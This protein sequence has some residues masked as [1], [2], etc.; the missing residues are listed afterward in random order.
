MSYREL[1][2]LCEMARTLKYPR[3]LSI[4]NFRNPN[5]KLVAELLQ[6]IVKKFDPSSNLNAQNIETEQDRVM[7][8]KQAVLLLLQNS[9]LKL[10]PKK[11]YQ[12]DGYAVQELIP[13]LKILYDASKG[14]EDLESVAQ[15][16][17]IKQKISSKM[18]EVRITRQLSAQ[19]PET[20]AALNDLLTKQIYFAKQRDRAASRAIALPEAEKTVQQAISAITAE[21]DEI[22]SRLNNVASDEAELDEKIERKKREYEQ[23]QKRLAKL[24]SFRPQYMDEY[25]KYEERLKQLYTVYVTNYRNLSYL[26]KVHDDLQTADRQKQ[27]ENERAMRIAVEKMRIE[28]EKNSTLEMDDETEAPLVERKERKVFGNM[29]DA[30]MSDEEVD[31]DE[32]N[33]QG[34]DRSDDDG[35]VALDNGDD[36]KMDLSS[37]DDF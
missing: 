21:S 6:W 36:E 4:E 11:L 12:A 17:S 1:R 19:L 26:K 25:E 23:M 29:M 37:G 14:T 22:S 8:I 27:D 18:Q 16:N 5:F 31:E 3:L 28:Q 33:V 34:G 35:H 20:G 30:G 7:F 15:W 32:D 9:R 10:N 2:N 13:A 24:Q